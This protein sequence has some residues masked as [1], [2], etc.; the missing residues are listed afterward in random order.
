MRLGIRI[1]S[2]A[3]AAACATGVLATAT[4]PAWAAASYTVQQDDTYW[5]LSH[6]F[7][8]SIA[9][10]EAA[11][12]THPWWNLYPGLHLIIPAGRASSTSAA[13]IRGASGSGLLTGPVASGPVGAISQGSLDLIARMAIAEEGNRSYEDQLGIAAVVV[14]RL[15]NGGFGSTVH[16]VLFAP[17][18]FTP[19]S[20]GYFYLVS[21]TAASLR[22]ARAAAAGQDPTGGA[23]YFYDPG[24]GVTSSWIYNRT[25]TTIIDG[26]VYAK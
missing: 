26:T 14:N 5:S 6:R 4:A 21:P 18:Q 10:L 9:A 16:A 24:Q 11:N 12:P 15:R 7:G 1:R 22:A 19:I 25:V 17:Y 8:V 20:N 13:Y 3:I 23:L 2:L